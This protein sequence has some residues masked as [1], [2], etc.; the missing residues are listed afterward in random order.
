MW[1]TSS[2]YIGTFII[3]Y[4][5]CDLVIMNEIDFSSYADNNTPYFVGN[6]YRRCYYQ[7]TKC[8][9]NTFPMVL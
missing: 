3:Q 2:I 8:I 5:L 9:P 7:F 1:D 4:F 6:K